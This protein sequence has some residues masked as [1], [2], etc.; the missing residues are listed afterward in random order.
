M[1]CPERALR[2]LGVCVGN[3]PLFMTW[4][5][6]GRLLMDYEAHTYDWRYPGLKYALLSSVPRAI[7]ASLWRHDVHNKP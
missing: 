5:G 3:D 4:T 1:F 7:I 2:F 6:S